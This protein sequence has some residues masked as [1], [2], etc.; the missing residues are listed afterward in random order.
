LPEPRPARSFLEPGQVDALLSAA[1]ELEARH[2]G[3]DWEKVRRIRASDLSNVALAHE[4]RVSDVLVSK[5]R[6][7]LIWNGEPGARNRN[8]VARHA[9]LA[10]LVLAG[11]RISELC[12]LEGRDVDLA[13][14][15]IRIRREITKSDAGVRVIPLVPGLRDVLVAHRAERPYGP[16]DFVFATRTGRP[17][18]PDNVRARIVA[19]AHARADELL[20]AREALSIERLTPHTLRRTFASILAECG[21]SPR[22]AMYLLGHTDP[23]LTMSVYQHVLDMSEGAAETLERLLGGA[24]DE[25]GH[26]LSGRRPRRTTSGAAE[27]SFDRG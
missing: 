27:S 3:L 9:I 23:K 13:G 25:V 16:A 5:V 10:T 18:H 21:V 15:R 4:L 17:N 7:R 6:R 12:G 11:V 2:R 19:P 22:R 24:L 8:D 20:A 14:R 1:L 26:V